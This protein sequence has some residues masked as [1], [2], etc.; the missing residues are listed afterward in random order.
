MKRL[1]VVVRAD[2]PIGLQMAQ[3]C[4]AVRAFARTCREV[5]PG[6]NLVVLNAHG[7]G[8][9]LRL[10]YDCPGDTVLFREPDH[11]NEF[12]AF[13]AS[14]EARQHLSSLPLAGSAYVKSDVRQT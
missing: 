4:H 13:A 12:T 1:Y 3:A 10:W 2:L 14:G 6:E 5:D 8:Q 7:E 9:L 11:Q